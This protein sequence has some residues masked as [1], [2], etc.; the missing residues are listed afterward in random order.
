MTAQIEPRVRAALTTVIDPEMGR[1]VVDL[2][3]IYGVEISPSGAVLVTM[4]T[5]TRFCPLAGVLREMVA[6]AVSGVDGVTSAVVKLTYEP[7]WT[8]QMIGAR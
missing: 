4:T 7:A 5:T 8:P 6:A 1:S 2:G 3:L